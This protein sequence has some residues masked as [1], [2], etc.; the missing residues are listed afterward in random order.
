MYYPSEE[1][2]ITILAAT[3]VLE[4]QMTLGMMLAV[5]YIIGQLNRPVEQLMNF[6]YASQM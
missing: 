1:Y 4:G 2:L 6:I 3:S 5:Q